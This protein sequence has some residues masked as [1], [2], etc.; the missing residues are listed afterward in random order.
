MI[1]SYNFFANNNEESVNTNYSVIFSLD[2]KEIV[3]QTLQELNQQGKTVIIV[4][5]DLDLAERLGG[6]IDIAT[7][8]KNNSSKN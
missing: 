8:K 4:T 1:N 3:I 7:L 6:G 2:Q 5:H